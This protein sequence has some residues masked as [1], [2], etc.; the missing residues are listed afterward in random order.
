MRVTQ[1]EQ[2]LQ[3]KQVITVKQHIKVSVLRTIWHT[4]A[5]LEDEEFLQALV[6]LNDEKKSLNIIFMV[7]STE[8]SF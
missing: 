5:D 7:R 2:R 6:Q 3:Q 1:L 4:L 8:M